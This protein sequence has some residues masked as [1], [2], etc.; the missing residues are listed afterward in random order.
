[1]DLIRM[2][3]L[4]RK[5]TEYLPFLEWFQSLDAHEQSALI[6]KLCCCAYQ[7]GVDE[8]VYQ[9]AVQ[10][11]GL[12]EDQKFLNL[13]RQVQGTSGLNV[14]GLIE[15]LRHAPVTDR[16]RAFKLFVYLFGEAE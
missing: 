14:G 9:V 10:D 16:A 12:A 8:S 2:N 1:M 15:W 4:V 13:M 7:A 6:G 3:Q 11:A 5:Q